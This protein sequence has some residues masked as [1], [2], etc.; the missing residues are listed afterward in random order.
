MKIRWVTKGTFLT[1]NSSEEI[2]FI[3]R[4]EPFLWVDT[5]VYKEVEKLT[6]DELL[7][8]LLQS[9]SAAGITC[10]DMIDDGKLQI[11]VKSPGKGEYVINQD[12]LSE[13]SIA[14]YYEDYRD[15]SCTLTDLE[16]V[17]IDL[18]VKSMKQIAEEDYNKPTTI[19]GWHTSLEHDW[20]FSCSHCHKTNW[21]MGS[22]VPKNC[23]YCGRSLKVVENKRDVIDE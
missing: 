21:I 4:T 9:K 17:P 7:Y 11:T 12:N 15:R 23:C 20:Q 16:S 3:G 2:A 1:K 18:V 22:E 8:E 5:G 19:H 10:V 13:Y 14:N 6:L